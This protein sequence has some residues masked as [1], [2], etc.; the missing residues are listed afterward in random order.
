MN[1]L[2]LLLTFTMFLG[3]SDL[4]AQA[5]KDDMG[6]TVKALLLD[7]QTLNGGDFSAF[8]AYHQGFE[9]GFFK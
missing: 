4:D 7:Y 1:K 3:V 6:I 9:L 5:A 8:Q 2:I